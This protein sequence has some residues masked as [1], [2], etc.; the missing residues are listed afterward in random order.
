ML[1][2][3]LRDQR[4]IIGSPDDCV[5]H[6]L[7]YHERLGANSYLLQVPWASMPQVEVLEAVELFGERVIP[8]LRDV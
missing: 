5:E 1:V 3:A 6:V 2:E 7:R 4:F 8:R